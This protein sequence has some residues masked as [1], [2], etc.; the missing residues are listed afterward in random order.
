[1]IVVACLKDEPLLRAR[2]WID[3]TTP[4]M[5]HAEH[6]CKQP[7]QA[8]TPMLPFRDGQE[9]RAARIADPQLPGDEG[10]PE[11][12][13]LPMRPQRQITRLI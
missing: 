8:L 2:H 7:L 11:L 3:V 12:P 10:E 4:G 5:E 9:F 1:M 6:W 13:L